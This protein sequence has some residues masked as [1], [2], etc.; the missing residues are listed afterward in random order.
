ME[1]HVQI[2]YPYCGHKNTAIVEFYDDTLTSRQI[3][4]CDI[5]EGGC[6]RP[7]VVMAHLAVN[8]TVYGLV[9]LGERGTS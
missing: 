6:D 2:E 9:G 5:E 8:T 1:T 7:F 4:F 3:V